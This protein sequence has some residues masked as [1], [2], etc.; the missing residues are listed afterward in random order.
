MPWVVYPRIEISLKGSMGDGWVIFGMFL[1][2]LIMLFLRKLSKPIKGFQKYSIFIISLIS[3]MLVIYKIYNFQI[4]KENLNPEDPYMVTAS[5]GS[6][7][8]YGLYL[9]GI[10]SAL[11]CVIAIIFRSGDK[12]IVR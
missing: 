2:I 10:I 11:L 3:L 7:L 9:L 12:N 4:E 5:A 6:Y 1:I 8:G